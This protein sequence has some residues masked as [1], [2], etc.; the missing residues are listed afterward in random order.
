MCMKPQYPWVY[1]LYTPKF[2]CL[3]SGA[4]GSHRD[5]SEGSGENNNDRMVYY[6]TS[7]CRVLYSHSIVLFSVSDY[8]RG[9]FAQN[10]QKIKLFSA[11]FHGY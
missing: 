1:I 4:I 9:S 8:S 10:K 7:E 2:T 3:P 5:R 11:N 6:I